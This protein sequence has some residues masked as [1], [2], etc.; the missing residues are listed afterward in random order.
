MEKNKL[1]EQVIFHV[2]IQ[3][4]FAVMF[5]LGT[6]YDESIAKAVYS[7]GDLIAVMVTTFGIYPFFAS[8]V[9][10]T[11]ALTE[12]TVHSGLNKPLKVLFCALCGGLALYSGFSGSKALM[13]VDCLGE[14]FPFL[15]RNMP[16]I[17]CVCVI[18]VYPLFFAGYKLA[19]KSD[20]KL[21]AKKIIGLIAVMLAALIVMETLKSLFSRPRYR[22]AVKG[23]GGIG[24]V[25]WYT[26]F[27]GAAEF[28][29]SFGLEKTDFRSFPSGHSLLSISCVYILYSLAW[30][31]PQ[32][33]D[34]QNLMCIC[35]FIFAVIVMFTRMLLGAHY[36]SDV[37]AGAAIGAFLSLIFTLI[38][39]R[40]ILNGQTVSAEEAK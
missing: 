26:P 29:A 39:H 4:V 31:F 25:P 19:G 24:F 17:L 11:G 30:L 13:S 23:Y 3:I 18:A 5:V 8:G 35:G 7:P 34:K 16:V 15:N 12:R 40:I 10:F 38:Q 32:L 22:I 21:L 6:F 14:V 1:K 20:D 2:G 33:K 37:S 36:L 27:S 9:L 28:V